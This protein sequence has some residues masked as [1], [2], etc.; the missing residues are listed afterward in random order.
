MKRLGILSIALAAAL[1]LAACGGSSDSASEKASTTQADPGGTSTPDTTA[2]DPTTSVAPTDAPTTTSANPLADGV[3]SCDGLTVG[4]DMAE[5][6]QG[7]MQGD[8]IIVSLGYDCGVSG[9]E[10]IYV[11]PDED[12]GEIYFGVPG[13]EAKKG[14][15]S[16]DFFAFMEA[17]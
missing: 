3:P 5:F 2:D 4:S 17:C 16:E 7:C 1:S 11:A 14:A 13:E 9:K 10:L 15:T 6:E 8:T 12:A